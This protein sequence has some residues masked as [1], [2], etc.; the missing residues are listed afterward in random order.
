[1]LSLKSK[2]KYL[3]VGTTHLSYSFK[4]KNSNSDFFLIFHK[5][6]SLKK[7]IAV[8]DRDILEISMDLNSRDPKL[9]EEKLLN[10]FLFNRS[11]L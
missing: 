4:K 1:M 11:K 3:L 8:M 7:H 6:Y 9:S 2:F 5:F 10:L